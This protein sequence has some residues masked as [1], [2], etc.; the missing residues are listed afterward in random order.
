MHCDR[1]NWRGM[2]LGMA[3]SLC[4][5]ILSFQKNKKEK[6]KIFACFSKHWYMLLLLHR[7]IKVACCRRFIEC[8]TSDHMF[9]FWPR[10]AIDA[11]HVLYVFGFVVLFVFFVLVVL[12][13]FLVFLFVLVVLVVLVV[14]LVLLPLVHYIVQFCTS[15]CTSNSE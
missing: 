14:L 9:E 2:R 4:P 12:V 10:L 1:R 8:K 13:V 5:K 7:N 6:E 11:I 3:P 15:S